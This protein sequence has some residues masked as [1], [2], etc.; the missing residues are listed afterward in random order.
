MGG[1]VGLN[2][3]GGAHWDIKRRLKDRYINT[4]F[5]LDTIVMEKN[6]ADFEERVIKASQNAQHI[7]DILR[8]HSSVE[9]VY[10]PKG[11]PTQQLYE[12]NKRPGKGYGYLLSIRFKTPAAAIA[13]HDVLDVAKGP[14]LGTNFTLG[15]AYTLFAHYDELQWAEE[16]GVVKHL[17]ES[18]WGSRMRDSWTRSSRQLWM[19]LNERALRKQLQLAEY[20]AEIPNDVSSCVTLSLAYVRL[21][22]D[23][24][25]DK[26]KFLAGSSL[27]ISTRLELSI[28][29]F[30]R[31][32]N[33][34]G[35]VTG[36]NSVAHNWKSIFG[37]T[38]TSY[39]TEY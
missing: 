2:P 25:N 20:P 3:N 11:S 8:K 12:K 38:T 27:D 28:Y 13:F 9:Q 4:N 17:Y 6:S 21:I 36:Y 14:N 16:Y 5:P 19:Q 33:R 26:H 34:S 7:A 23:D 1:S 29:V 24:P 39:L 37:S 30:P 18:V 15:C 10:Y 31:G 32:L 35:G 22:R